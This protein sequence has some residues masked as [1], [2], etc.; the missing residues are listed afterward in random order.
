MKQSLASTTTPGQDT[1]AFR[2]ISWL[3]LNYGA[4]SLAALQQDRTDLQRSIGSGHAE[5]G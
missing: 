4:L 5:P 2:Q 3:V 1:Q